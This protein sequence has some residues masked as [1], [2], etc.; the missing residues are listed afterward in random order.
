MNL[1]ILRSSHSSFLE[2]F[3]GVFTLEVKWFSLWTYVGVL[4]FAVSNSLTTGIFQ[5]KMHNDVKLPFHVGR[6]S[7]DLRVMQLCILSRDTNSMI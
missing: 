7:F 3:L 1:Q 4:N 6:N 5:S 2:R